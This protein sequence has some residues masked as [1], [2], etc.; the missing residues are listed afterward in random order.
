MRALLCR[1]VL[2]CFAMSSLFAETSHPEEAVVGDSFALWGTSMAHEDEEGPPP[3]SLLDALER[4][5]NHNPALA[6]TLWQFRESEANVCQQRLL[7]NPNIDIELD[8]F[9][10]SGRYRGVEF[11][12]FQIELTKTIETS[13]KRLRRTVLA[14]QQADLA[15]WSYM[16]QAVDTCNAVVKAYIDVLVAQAQVPLAAE[17]LELAENVVS[18]NKEGDK[19][20]TTLSLEKTRARVVV[21][22][23][24]VRLQEA[25]T[26]LVTARQ[27]LASTWGTTDTSDFGPVIGLL[28][29]VPD[30]P[31][32]D[33][34]LPLLPHNPD[35]GRFT[36]ARKEA[37][38]QV[39]H[40]RAL[41]IPDCDIFGTFWVFNGTNDY[42]FSAGIAVDIPICNRNQGNILK[43]IYSIS[44]VEERYRDAYVTAAVNLE[45]AQEQLKLAVVQAKLYVD[46]AIPL[47][48]DAYFAAQA[49]YR[50]GG[51]SYLT[52]L[53]AQQT[54]AEAELTALQILGTAHKARADIDRFIGACVGRYLEYGEQQ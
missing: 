46:E 13:W 25:K 39:N 51:L 4:A 41:A 18:S 9:V 49:R 34:L 36:S 15:Q 53:S 5:F 10:G 48:R 6:A 26:S 42:A 47:A 52:L 27:R 30:V 24:R 22:Q 20:T 12:S 21:V 8:D 38:A 31:E 3:L 16:S 28:W 1:V 17:L 45:N 35:I 54:L 14:R 44:E 23:N 11:S 29:P 2:C 7:P 33:D 40:Q 43:A 32:L 37:V 50:G 19:N